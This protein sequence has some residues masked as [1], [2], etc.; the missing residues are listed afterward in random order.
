MQRFGSNCEAHIHGEVSHN[1]GGNAYPQV[2]DVKQQCAMH[3]LS[4]CFPVKG[5]DVCHHLSEQTLVKG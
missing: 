2:M 5:L 1:T 3:H 4:M